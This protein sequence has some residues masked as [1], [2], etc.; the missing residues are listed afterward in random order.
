MVKYIIFLLKAASVTVG[1]AGAAFLC[2]D[3]VMECV[4]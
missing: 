1:V 4:L 2:V 3:D